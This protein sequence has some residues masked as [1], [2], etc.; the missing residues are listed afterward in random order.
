MKFLQILTT[1][2]VWAVLTL[3]IIHHIGV[4]P[5]GVALSALTAAVTTIGNSVLYGEAHEPDTN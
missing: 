4:T 2:T 5:T 3:H 1:I